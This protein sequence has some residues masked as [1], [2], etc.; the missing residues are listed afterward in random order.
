MARMG[1][2]FKKTFTPVTIMVVPHEDL[3]C[4]N[5][6]VPLIGILFS[7]L[8]CALGCF[9]LFSLAAAGLKYRNVEEK[10]QYYSR[11][12]FEWQGTVA[13]FKRVEA[14]FR[15]LV[16]LPSRERTLEQA[17]SPFSGDLDLDFLREELEKT[18][19]GMDEIRD[20]LR[21][22]KDLYLA[23][24]RGFPVSAPISSP[25]GKRPNPLS[26]EAGF[27]S[28]VDLSAATGTPIRATA[29]G[30]V[31]H[32]GWTP[33]SGYVVVLEHGHGFSTIY[34]H[35]KKNAVNAGQKVAK[36]EIIAHVGS[37]GR[38]TGPHLHYEVWK[39]GRSVNPQ[40]FLRGG[41]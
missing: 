25:Y 15:S 10:V 26:G 22:Q 23:T 12:F 41:S 14:E 21:G 32:S 31:S 29:D 30:V 11:Y 24:P 3:P 40:A 38:S 6:R 13:A 18:I 28:G 4:L 8:T 9:Y 37:T 17:S 33:Q 7:L 35:N 20:Y 36:G 19:A 1:F 2:L 5:I 34:A 39:N 16:P 27:H